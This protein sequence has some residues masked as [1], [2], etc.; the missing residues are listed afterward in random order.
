MWGVSTAELAVLMLQAKP[1]ARAYTATVA[2]PVEKDHTK[3]HWGNAGNLIRDIKL[4][5]D[6][7]FVELLNV[8]VFERHNPY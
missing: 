5:G 8:H 7:L 4:P 2:S 6:V 3:A 1:T